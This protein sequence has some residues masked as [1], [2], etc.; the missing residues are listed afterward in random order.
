MAAKLLRDMDQLRTP[1]ALIGVAGIIFMF[2]YA[3]CFPTYFGYFIKVVETETGFD[4]EYLNKRNE[5]QRI[6]KI[7][8]EDLIGFSCFDHSSQVLTKTRLIFRSSSGPVTKLTL[9][10]KKTVRG[11][12]LQTAEIVDRILKKIAAFNQQGHHKFIERMPSFLSSK[13]GLYAIIMPVLMLA[14]AVVLSSVKTEKSILV[15]FSLGAMTSVLMLRRWNELK[16]I[17]KS[18]RRSLDIA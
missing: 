3:I 7:N 18:N 14:I 1:L 12:E 15:L 9:L 8:L 6:E 16:Q 13:P 5:V 11:V 4:L 2:M 17:E 10:H